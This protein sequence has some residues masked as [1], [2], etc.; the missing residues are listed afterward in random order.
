MFPGGT[1]IGLEIQRA[2]GHLKEVELV[3]AGS[4]ADVHGPP[5]YRHYHPLPN[6]GE[7]GWL[8]ALQR[9][10]AAESIDFVYP[11]HDH[12][13]STLADHVDALGARVVGP[14]PETCRLTRSKRAT[15]AAL[16]GAL[17]VPRVFEDPAQVA[18]FPVFVK[19]DRSQG[20]QG[21]ALASD[22]AELARWVALGSDLV[23]EYLPGDE[24]TIDCFSDRERGL[25]FVRGRTRMRTRAGISV[26][27]RAG[28]D[29]ALF[30]RY[31]N[32]IA[33]RI[34]LHGAWF[35]QLRGDRE[36]VPTLLEVGPRI[37]G[38]MALNRVLGVNFPLLSIY[39]AMRVPVA[40]DM[41][42]VDAVIDRPLTNRYSHD[43]TY[44]TVY[45]DLDDTLI[46]R[47]EVNVPLVALLYQCVNQ[48]HRLVLLTRHREDVPTTLARFRLSELWDA[49]VR[50]ADEEEK[51]DHISERD[52][53][54]IDDSF[55]ERRDA[56]ARLGIATFDSS[57]IELLVDHRL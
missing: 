40:V 47:G 27:S 29:Q 46:V 48:G 56:H 44:S 35:F 57:M 38:T 14:P 18:D 42:E 54:L 53:I 13:L 9:L 50:V 37:A 21:A 16:D 39:E 3:A 4:E 15:Y 36:G 31:A 30:E 19:P 33:S 2:L 22:G 24:Y 51:A 20:S 23:M 7:P 25:L 43:L 11:A 17:P 32:A 52:A 5:A 6:V 45:V 28:G 55:R 8:E 12:V 34:D 10:I 49:V 26:W 41:L 1:E